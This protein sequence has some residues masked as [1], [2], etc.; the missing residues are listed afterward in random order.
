MVRVQARG[1]SSAEI[2]LFC[3]LVGFKA[4]S[5]IGPEFVEW[6]RLRTCLFN[7]GSEDLACYYDC[8]ASALLV[9]LSL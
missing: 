6:A 7:M 5:L 3:L 2:H 1:H 4:G 9:E 8:K